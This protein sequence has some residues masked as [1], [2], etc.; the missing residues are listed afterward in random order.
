MKKINIR[1]FFQSIK[2]DKLK[3]VI[4]S[5]ADVELGAIQKLFQEEGL[6]MIG[7]D[8]GSGTKDTEGVE[9]FDNDSVVSED[10]NG[11]KPIDIVF[12]DGAFMMKY[13]NSYIS[14]DPTFERLK[15]I[16]NKMNVPN[17][18][19]INKDAKNG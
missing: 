1:Y 18:I 13:G 8:L 9:I 6:K 5:L 11:G 16:G 14:I 2:T 4:L 10:R 7:R 3:T 19:N 12:K 17:W 15:V